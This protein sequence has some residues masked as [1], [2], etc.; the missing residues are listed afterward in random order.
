M[1]QTIAFTQAWSR[2][3]LPTGGAEKVYLLIEA[4]GT[5]G[6]KSDGRA[7]INLSLVL[8]RSASMT[9]EPLQYS[10]KACQFVAEQMDVNDLLSLVA[11]DDEVRTVFPPSKVTHKDL[12]KQRINSIETGGS[13][14]LSGGMIEGAQ[15]VRK[16]KEDGTVNRVILLSD[17]HANAGVTDRNKLFAIAAEYRSSGVGI[18]TMGVGDGFDEELMEG[19]AEHGGGNF[20][21]IDKPDDIPS[22]FNQELQGLLS[23]VAQNVKL[24]LNPSELTSIVGIY[25]YP[26]EEQLGKPVV[27][28]GDL[29]QNEVKS[30]LLE[31]AF[32]PHT[33]GTHNVLQL[34]WEY[35]DVTE[36]AEAC[37]F[38]IDVAAEFTSDINLLNELGNPEV[39]KQVELTKS[40]KVIEEAMQAFD[41]GDMEHG[42]ML[43]KAQADQML[44]MSIELNSPIMREESEKLYSQL[45]NFEYSS[46]TRK[47]LHQE[48]YRRMKRK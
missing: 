41:N 38:S 44:H 18:T 35:I 16:G 20:Y 46:K 13:T 29:Y 43:L 19:I 23:V 25:G 15:H 39:Q 26:A 30:I 4:K 42:Q 36:G 5:E 1:K 17:G 28:T 11:F 31:L 12:I 45:D 48:K 6:E 10:K 47:E 27:H 21:Y 2:P 32:H 8:D 37:T 22:I 40:A 14:N 7:P 33:Q 3:Y 34:N 24:T 9:G